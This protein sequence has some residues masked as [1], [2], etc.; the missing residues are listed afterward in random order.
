MV[1]VMAHRGASSLAP[2]NSFPAFKKAIEHNAD[3]IE[4]DVRR[5]ASGELVVMHD[6]RIDRTTNGKGLV[7]KMTLQQ[8]KKYHLKKMKK[9]MK[10][11]IPTL[12]EAIELVKGKCKLNIEI[13]SK[14]NDFEY[15]E[16]LSD[17]L[18]KHDFEKQV[19]VSSYR[20]KMLKKLVEINPKIETAAL[21]IEKKS[22][23]L[24]LR[25]LYYIGSYIRKT[26]H[27]KASAMNL[28][29]QFITKRLMKSAIKHGL[30]VNAWTV[31]NNKSIERMKLIGV[32]GIITNYPQKF[33]KLALK[34]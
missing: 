32:D 26:K 14:K 1:S 15:V 17:L 28:P 7:A 18:K 25:R 19:I 29:Y 4:V 33:D 12:E 2:E 10:K 16:I 23:S 34:K 21:F 24:I 3:Y 30:K 6:S 5:C 20:H 9:G 8:I 31:N 27:I 13:K 22:P 11:D